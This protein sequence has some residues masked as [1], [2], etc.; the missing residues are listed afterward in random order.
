VTIDPT[1]KLPPYRQ[2]ADI[3]AGQIRDGTLAKGSRIPTESEL[4]EM[5]EVSRSTVRRTVAWLRE[6]GLVETV[7]QRG[8]YVL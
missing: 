6:A 7:P 8:T 1:A 2:L 5:Y 4:I 3:I